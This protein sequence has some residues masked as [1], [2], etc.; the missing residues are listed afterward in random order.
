MRFEFG[1]HLCF[2]ALILVLIQSSWSVWAQETPPPSASPSA[3]SSAVQDL[4][5]A[6]AKATSEEE[7]EGAGAD[8]RASG[9]PRQPL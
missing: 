6:L 3:T 7:I 2:L 9:G 1:G 8:R 5:A 4:A